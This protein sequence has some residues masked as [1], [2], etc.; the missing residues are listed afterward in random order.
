MIQITQACLQNEMLDTCYGRITYLEWLTKERD[1]INANPKRLTEITGK[2]G[3][4]CLVETK[5]K[6][7][8]ALVKDVYA[9]KPLDINDWK[10]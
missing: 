4:I 10:A 2:Q 7:I 5:Y 1:R 9:D 8:I 3:G 6:N